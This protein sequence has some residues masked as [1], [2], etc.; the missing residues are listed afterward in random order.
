MK[1]LRSTSS[2]ALVVTLVLLVLVLLIVVGYLGITRSDRATTSTYANRLRAKMMA[3][4]SVAAATHLLKDN[5]NYGNYITAMSLPSPSPAPLYTEVYRPTDPTDPS[6]AKADDFLRLDNAAGDILVS[7]ATASSSP[8]PDPRPT[9]PAI[10]TPLPASSPFTIPSPVPALSEEQLPP[11][12]PSPVGNSY[13]FNQTVRLG[14]SNVARLV[15]P[16]PSPSSPAALGQWVNV[17]NSAGDLVGRYAFFIED[18]SMKVNINFAGNNLGGSNMRVNDLA[19][20]APVTMPASQIEEMDPAAVLPTTA[21]RASADATLT[22]LGASGNRISSRSTLG[23]LNEW[24]NTTNFPDYAHLATVLSR[25]D[26]TTARGWQ[27]LDLNQI[28]TNAESGGNAAKIAAATRIANWIRDAWTGST[29]IASLQDYQLHGENRLRQQIAADIV[30][31]I[32]TDNGNNIPTDMGDVVPTGYTDAVPVI[33]IEKVPYLV[34]VEVLYEAS[35][36]TYPT[37]TP[38]PPAAGTYTATLKMKLQFRF[39]NLYETQLDL[40]DSIGTNGQGRIEVQGVPVVSKNGNEV[41][42]V[43]TD[44]PFVI[45]LSDLRPVNGTGTTIPAG[46]DGVSDSGARTF[47]T[48][49]L[50]NQSVTFT[51]L[52]SNDAKA[53]L[54]AGKI[55]VKVFGN[56]GSGDYRLDDTAIITN[57][58]ATGWQQSGSNSIGDFLTQANPGP[59]QV[60][61]I[62]LAYGTAPGSSTVLEYGDPRYRGRLISDRWRNISRTDKQRVDS[63]VDKAEL[64]PRTYGFDWYDNAG[65]RPLA[66][67]RNAPM[68]NVGELGNVAATEY[69]WRTLY[70][71]YPERPANTTQSGPVTDIPLRRSQSLDYVLVDLFR[72]QSTQPRSGA[73]NINGQQRF[74]TQ[75]QALAPLFFGEAVSTLPFLTQIMVDRLCTS[76]GSAAVSPIFD[77]RI[78]VGPPPDNTPR[79]PF[80]HIGEFAPVLSRLVN[81]STR[82]AGESRSTVTYSMLRTNPTSTGELN[83][84]YERDMQVEQEFRGVSN[85]ITT[86]GNLFRVLYVGQAIKDIPRNGVRNG[87]VDG[88]EEVAAEYLGEAFIERQST[89]AAPSPPPNPDALTTSNSTYNLVANRVITE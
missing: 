76:S 88:K 62:N 77:R 48:D 3:D 38:S 28:V 82:V 53:R 19:S 55:T 32:D 7:R 78:N 54:Q 74:G 61:S 57:L 1:K 16:S 49:W 85:S 81:S 56:K 73:M 46:T 67:I 80:F 71:Q 40:A 45:K 70:L 41:F 83:V 34:A 86:R 58:T 39:L 8:G 18:E 69:P 68:L 21:N 47:Q 5:T 27:R 9:P 22:G 84:N 87:R 25:D 10:P 75:Q 6:H 59:L 50:K 31:Y 24:G 33:G 17:R 63:F 42:N 20:P 66:F 37:P 35:N 44:P 14:S 2:F 43:E 72:T 23:L 64:L 89:F 60:A 11:A 36:S 4:S 52:P 30:D 26:N 15:Q 29:T 12:V 51:V 65:D 13:N 79:R